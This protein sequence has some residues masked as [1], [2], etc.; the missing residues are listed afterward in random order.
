MSSARQD[1]GARRTRTRATSNALRSSCTAIVA[2][3]VSG[4]A[5]ADI[6]ALTPNK[7]NTLYQNADGVQ[8]SNGVGEHFFA[9]RTPRDELR[10]GLL[11][12]DLSSVP[13]NADIASASLRLNMS[14]TGTGPATFGLHRLLAD[15]GQGA[16]DAAGD[17]GM[18]APAATGDATWLY[19]QFDTQLWIAEG[20]DFVPDA[21]AAITVDGIGMYEWTSTPQLV[22]DVQFWLDNPAS[23]F[24]WCVRGEEQI[25]SAKRFDTRES[26]DAGVRPQL[27]IE[28][29]LPCVGDLDSD[30]IVGLG[31]L[32]RLLSNFG[33]PSGA[34]GEDGDIDSDGDVDLSD[35]AALLSNFG[36]ACP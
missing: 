8:L 36:I 33:T 7:D 2:L 6:V 25:A 4:G 29:T 26:L 14:R 9:G 12:F 18:G 21:A 23:N 11:A 24:G 5:I 16:S 31:D 19:R 13:S 32:A 20:G 3:L 27:T 34:T 30:G 1:S 28:F 15:W 22:A 35:L 17:E 10:R